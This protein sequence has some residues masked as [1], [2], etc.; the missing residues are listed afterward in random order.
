MA[1]QRTCD[2]PECP[3]IITK[4]DSYTWGGF[5]QTRHNDGGRAKI[6]GKI[7]IR[8]Y[9]CSRP[10]YRL[11]LAE[12]ER[13]FDENKTEPL[14]TR[15][16]TFVNTWIVEVAPYRSAD[17]LPVRK[18][19]LDVA[20]AKSAF[21]VT[22]FGDAPFTTIDGKMINKALRRL[23][24]KNQLGADTRN[25]YRKILRNI[26]VAA[27]N[28]KLVSHERFMELFGD[29]TSSSKGLVPKQRDRGAGKKCQL[30][31]TKA[32]RLQMRSARTEAIDNPTSIDSRNYLYSWAAFQIGIN[33][34][35]R[36]R[37]IFALRWSDIQPG[38]DD[39]KFLNIERQVEETKEDAQRVISDFT[40]AATSDHSAREP[41]V[42]NKPY[43]VE[44]FR[45]LKQFQ[46]EQEMRATVWN[47]SDLIFT[48]NDGGIVSVTPVIDCYRDEVRR[49]GIEWEQRTGTSKDGVAEYGIK[50]PRFHQTKNTYVT[51]CIR[52]L[53]IP[54]A[55]VKQWAGHADVDMTRH[56]YDSTGEMPD[57][58]VNAMAQL[59]G[60]HESKAS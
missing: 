17:G 9:S 33:S 44:V 11:I 18:K 48:D 28:D 26:F 5:T 27:R 21:W 43:M 35:A 29:G 30:A 46:R 34:G 59:D 41:M 7:Y 54:E 15:F 31:F 47:D 49:L 16:S 19:V 8:I 60:V 24:E 57:E 52:D 32:Q 36:E 6:R 50:S 55:Q 25:V 56:Y 53:N 20:K 38:F 2:A 42:L 10:H 45:T 4:D 51:S 3:T 40:K 37:E 22:E 39:P 12:A 13:D 14:D 23:R 1:K 58:I